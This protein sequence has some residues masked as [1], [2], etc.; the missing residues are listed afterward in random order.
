M[1]DEV[2]PAAPAADVQ[3]STPGQQVISKWFNEQICNR[4]IDTQ[5]YNLIFEAVE[6]LK[7][8]FK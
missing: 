6:D 3:V 5:T 4:A 7:Q 8:R 1:P 2:Q